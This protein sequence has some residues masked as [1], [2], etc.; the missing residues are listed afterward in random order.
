MRYTTER[1]KLKESSGPDPEFETIIETHPIRCSQD[2]DG[3]RTYGSMVAW[4]VLLMIPAEDDP[5]RWQPL[6]C[7]GC[8]TLL[9]IY[10]D[11]GDV[12]LGPQMVDWFAQPVTLSRIRL[13]PTT[14]IYCDEPDCGGGVTWPPE[15]KR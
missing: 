14:R 11:A 9:G 3:H 7:D 2:D 6:F 13:H 15:R 5:A 12:I 10:T 4:A 1:E 8:L